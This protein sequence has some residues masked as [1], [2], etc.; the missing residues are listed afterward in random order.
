MNLFHIVQLFFE[1][2]IDFNCN[3]IVNPKFHRFWIVKVLK[4]INNHFI[5][6][7][8]RMDRLKHRIGIIF[9]WSSKKISEKN[10]WSKINYCYR[11][12][13]PN[14]CIT[15]NRRRLVLKYWC[16]LAVL[17]EFLNKKLYLIAKRINNIQ[18]TLVLSVFQW[19]IGSIIIS[20]CDVFF[21]LL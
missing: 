3:L 4:T 20:T 15:L 19:T 1:K 13:G 5:I 18:N 12:G 11:I 2:N 7:L 9:G 16:L 17:E 6:V 10:L 14:R 21:F 8:N